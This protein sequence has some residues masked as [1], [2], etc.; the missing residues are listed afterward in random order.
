MLRQK[1]LTLVGAVGIALLASL[2]IVFNGRGQT[3]GANQQ[4]ASMTTEATSGRAR[5]L[6]MPRPRLLISAM[7]LLSIGSKRRR[8]L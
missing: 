5:S 1:R 7:Q 3:G 8:A 6:T 2:F 4:G